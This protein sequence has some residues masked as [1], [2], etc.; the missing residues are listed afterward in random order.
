[1]IRFG[2]LTEEWLVKSKRREKKKRKKSIQPTNIQFLKNVYVYYCIIFFFSYNVICVHSYVSTYIHKPQLCWT[3]FF[4]SLELCL[5]FIN[6]ICDGQ[7]HF[8]E[9]DVL[10]S[11]IHTFLWNLYVHFLFFWAMA[12]GKRW[13]WLK[14]ERKVWG[15][16]NTGLSTAGVT[17]L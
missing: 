13:R 10:F 5:I 15:Y 16:E 7:N 8:M 14:K 11:A 2:F 3:F 1:M 6:I 17:R 4:F 9:M 12:D